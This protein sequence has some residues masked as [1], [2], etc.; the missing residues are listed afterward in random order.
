M[1][2]SALLIDLLHS[3]FY[4]DIPNAEAK[5]WCVLFSNKVQW[6]FAYPYLALRRSHPAPA[7]PLFQSPKVYDL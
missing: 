6:M 3:F 2:A 1:V 4:D 5:L 7:L